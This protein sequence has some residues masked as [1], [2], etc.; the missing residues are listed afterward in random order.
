[1]IIFLAGVHGVGKTTLVKSCV[2]KIGIE[3][4]TASSIIQKESNR[5]NWDINKLTEEIETNQEIL[6]RGFTRIKTNKKTL[7]LDGHFVIRDSQG[8]IVKLPPDTFKR[9]GIEIVILLES[10]PYEIQKRLKKRGSNLSIQSIIEISK[11]E[12]LHA[13]FVCNE[14]KL[15]LIRLSSP[16]IYEFENSLKYF[17]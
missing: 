12:L 9:L 13:K 15:K 16:S 7:I 8:I 6:I 1:M 14:L 5:I 3:Y 11:E 17:L 2:D 10:N 4:A